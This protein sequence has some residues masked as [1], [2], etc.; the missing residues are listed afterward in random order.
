MLH[1]LQIEIGAYVVRVP[2]SFFPSTNSEYNY[3]F[4]GHIKA[5]TPIV[6]VSA[7]DNSVT[8]RDEDNLNEVRIEKTSESGLAI[9]KD[10]VIYFKTSNM[11]APVLLAQKNDSHPD[12]LAV[13]L[14]FVPSFQEKASPA[15]FE[16]VS[17][18]RPEP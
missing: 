7:P 12:E 6:Y 9:E 5:E 1:V 11:E 15:A 2:V 17:D 8:T 16:T 14:S 18:E 4:H 3:S 10:I 13:M